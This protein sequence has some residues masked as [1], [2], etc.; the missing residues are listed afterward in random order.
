MLSCSDTGNLGYKFILFI[1]FLY[2]EGMWTETK[3]TKLIRD[4]VE[5]NPKSSESKLS[6]HSQ[7]TKINS[8]MGSS[9]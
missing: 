6:F 5:P 4:I 7:T 9:A 8:S 1:I 3:F 2:H